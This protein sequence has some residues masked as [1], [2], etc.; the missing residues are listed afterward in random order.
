MYHR[1]NF[2]EGAPKIRGTSSVYQ[3]L[4]VFMYYSVLTEEMNCVNSLVSN[5]LKINELRGAIIII[6]E[7]MRKI[8]KKKKN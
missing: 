2:S 8:M 7:G 5:Y 4:D 1:N 3:Q 6:I